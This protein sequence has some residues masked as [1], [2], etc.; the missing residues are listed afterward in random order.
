M[1]LQQ[2]S[3]Y[4][5]DFGSVAIRAGELRISPSPYSV[6][7][8]TR[9]S[10]MSSGTE[11]TYLYDQSKLPAGKQYPIKPGVGLT[12]EIV[13]VGDAVLAVRP[14]LRPGQRVFVRERHQAYALC[15]VLTDHIVAIPDDLTDEA[16]L[17][18]R[19]AIVGIYAT[20]VAGIALGA[21]VHII[22]L[23]VIGQL[24][25]RIAVIAG[26]RP[27][28]ATDNNAL[29]RHVA[30]TQRMVEVEPPTSGTRAKVTD[31]VAVACSSA[32]AITDGLEMV[33]RG[34]TLALVGGGIRQMSVD[35]DEGVFR[36]NV[37]IVGA[38]EM[39]ADKRPGGGA[40]TWTDLL[41]L[42]VRLIS[43][44]SLNVDGIITHYFA[45]S[46]VVLAYQTVSKSK[47][48]CVGAVIDWGDDR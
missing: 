18:A 37:R 28:S 31:V 21:S 5:E 41:R 42:P 40:T 32:S 4:F 14:E 26:A 36:R 34:G 2:R 19:Q 17:L 3:V 24:L 20:R 9:L 7:V 11:S 10:L 12:G 27:V 13:H 48:E 30:A 8:R 47:D 6:V 45:P 43:D 38:H 16:M 39:G 29:R 25:A 23:G 33:A 46:D 35:L 44:G 22:G 1:G 15:D